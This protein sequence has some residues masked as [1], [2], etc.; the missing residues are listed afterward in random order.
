MVGGRHE[1][2]VYFDLVGK[3]VFGQQLA[4]VVEHRAEKRVLGIP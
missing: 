4:E 2:G 3:I 1:R